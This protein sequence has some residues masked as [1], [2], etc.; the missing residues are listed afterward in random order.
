[1]LHQD[2]HQELI[3]RS[4]AFSLNQVQQW[5][6]IIGTKWMPDTSQTPD[7]GAT[8][9][10]SFNFTNVYQQ[11]VIAILD[12]MTQSD[13]DLLTYKLQHLVKIHKIQQRQMDEFLNGTIP[14]VTPYDRNVP[15]HTW[16]ALAF[17]IECIIQIYWSNYTGENN[18]YHFHKKLQK[19]KQNPHESRISQEKVQDWL[20]EMFYLRWYDMQSYI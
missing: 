5:L 10:E 9:P 13:K 1:M 19:F 6:D 11:T 7:S 3:R 18:E 8:P 16:R 15:K 14:N 2:S 12:T 4:P 17:E 20:R